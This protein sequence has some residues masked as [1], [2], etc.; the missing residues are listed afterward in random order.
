MSRL[1]K[2]GTPAASV[3]E[4]RGGC[5]PE[6]AAIPAVAPKPAARQ[7]GLARRKILF[8]AAVVAAAGGSGYELVQNGTLP[9][10]YQLDKILGACGGDP[11]VPTVEAGPVST[12]RF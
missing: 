2:H 6:G 4:R 7:R 12:M 5:R 11:G 3:S 1:W 10:K 8:G 9:G